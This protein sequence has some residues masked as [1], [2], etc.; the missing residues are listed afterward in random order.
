MVSAELPAWIE[1]TKALGTPAASVLTAVIAGF[2]A[3][4]I[5]NMQ[6]ES[7]RQQAVTARNKLKLELYPQRLEIFNIV[8]GTIGLATAHGRLTA[9]EERKYL[10]GIAGSAWLFDD[11]VHSYLQNDFWRMMVDLGA[12]NAALE[13]RYPGQDRKTLAEQR[14]TYFKKIKDQTEVIEE[15]FKPF[16]RIET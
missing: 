9:D 13:D 10:V 7:S 3:Y 2:V 11:K 8:R 5:G 16:L 4:K 1:Y 14:A 12:G 6:A 15:L